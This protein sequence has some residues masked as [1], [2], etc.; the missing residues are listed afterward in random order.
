MSND[1]LNMQ[2]LILDYYR[3]IVN[4]SKVEWM[5][6]KLNPYTLY[7]QIITPNLSQI[8]QALNIV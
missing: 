3:K 7:V 4:Y 8:K 2:D 6:N 5:K 1:K